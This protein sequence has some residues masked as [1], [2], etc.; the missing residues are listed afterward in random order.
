MSLAELPRKTHVALATAVAAAFFVFMV[1]GI[2]ANTWGAS[3][4]ADA[5]DFTGLV[6]ALFSD[7][8]LALEVLGILLTAAL[9]G[10]MVIARPLNTVDDATNYSTKIRGDAMAD[11][12]DVSDVD[13]NLA[14]GSF[15]AVSYQGVE[16]APGDSSETGGEEE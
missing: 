8:V 6:D 14:G 1:I 3:S 12:Q 13:R 4:D 7:H 2:N 11:L 10:A 5:D 16:E 9:I 15:P